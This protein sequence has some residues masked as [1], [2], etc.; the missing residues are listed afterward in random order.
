MQ[1]KS[2]VQ[3]LSK[4]DATTKPPSLLL[5]S[6]PSSPWGV[7]LCSI[8]WCWPVQAAWVW[9]HVWSLMDRHSALPFF[10]ETG[11]GVNP[12]IVTPILNHCDQSLV[13][14]WVTCPPR[15]ITKGPAP[16]TSIVSPPGQEASHPGSFAGG[17]AQKNDFCSAACWEFWSLG[18]CNSLLSFYSV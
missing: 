9:E 14:A 16:V 13:W 15:Q 8:L 12:P 4:V 5:V 2:A 17:S 3:P 10:C 7:S 6:G 11:S 18:S 1:I